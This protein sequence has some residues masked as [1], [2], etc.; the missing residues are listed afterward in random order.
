MGVSYSADAQDQLPN[1]FF[2]ALYDVPVMAGLEEVPELSMKFHKPDR[3]I[4]QA[5]ALAKNISKNEILAFYAATLP[6]MGWSKIQ[7]NQ[8]DRDGERLTILV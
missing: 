5:G 2:E 7:L 4:S 1:V 3:R 8:Y 6:Q